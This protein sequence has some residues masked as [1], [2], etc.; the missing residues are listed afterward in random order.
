SALMLYAL[1]LVGTAIWAL[2]ESGPDFW[3]L[4]PRSG[5]RVVFGVWLRLLVS[6]RLEAPR[7]LGV[8]TLVGSLVIWAGVLVYACF[9]DPQ[10]VNGT[11]N[12]STG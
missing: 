12:A 8:Q 7:K 5:V 11:L 3:A 4:A 9:N 1:F 10:T 2:W 6:W